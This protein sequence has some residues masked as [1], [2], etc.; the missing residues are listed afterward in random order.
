MLPQSRRAGPVAR[1]GTGKAVRVRREEA[2]VLLDLGRLLRRTGRRRAAAERLGAARAIFERLGARPLADRCVH[3]L[4]ACGLEPPAT[5]RL[6]LT[7]QELSTATLVAGGLTNRQ[8]ARELLISVKT[9]EY[10]IGKI[11]TKL[12]VCSRVALAAKLAS[13]GPAS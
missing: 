13:Y 10:H 7:P 6:G 3:E 8:I 11:Y 9:V 5:V 4:E 2:R 1:P 12:G